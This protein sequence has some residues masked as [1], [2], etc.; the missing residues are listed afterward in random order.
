MRRVVVTGAGGIS[1][2]GDNWA[3]IERGLRAGR[4]AVRYMTE[5]D[6]YS[7]LNTRLAAPC[8][9]FQAPAEWTRKQLRS[10]GRVSQLAVR[11]SQLALVHA[12]LNDAEFLRGGSVGVACGSCVGSAPDVVD[13]ARMLIDC[14]GSRVNANTY[15]RMMQHTAAGKHPGRRYDDPRTLHLVDLL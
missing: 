4:N 11:A 13:F 1:A 10:Q 15:I 12:G 3:S 8:D 6:K 7:D 5:W 9:A 2:L 14:D